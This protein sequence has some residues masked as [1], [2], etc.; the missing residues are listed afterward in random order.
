MSEENIEE[1]KEEA[2]PS[3]VDGGETSAVIPDEVKPPEPGSIEYTKAVEDR[4]GKVTK[5]AYQAEA[6]AELFEKRVQ[7]L[8]SQTAKPVETP[9]APSFSEPEPQ[10]ASY[11]E[12]SQYVKDLASWQFRKEQTA[13]TANMTQQDSLNKRNQMES[14]FKTRVSESKIIDDHPDFYDKMRFVNL[15]PSIHEIV[16]TSDKGP[17]LALHLAENPDIMRDL[18]SISPLVAA[19][20]LGI[21]EAKLSGKVEKKTVTGALDGSEGK[22]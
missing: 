4:I 18:N 14:E 15:S 2:I 6:R 9:Q 12:N 16:L 11:E 5:K 13:F 22:A 19:R 8:E 17:E 3:A 21:I 20:K 1:V 10:E 7:E